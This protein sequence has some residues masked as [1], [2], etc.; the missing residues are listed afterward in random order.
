MCLESFESVFLLRAL[1]TM[2]DSLKTEL[3]GGVTSSQI[4]QVPGFLVVLLDP[5][6]KQISTPNYWAVNVV[7][8]K[9]SC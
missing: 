9:K 8:S 4:G 7:L 6:V 2:N 3:V 5:R 1:A